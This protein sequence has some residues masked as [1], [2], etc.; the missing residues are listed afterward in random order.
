MK[1]LIISQNTADR[2]AKERGVA[3]TE[4][5][6]VFAVLILGINFMVDWGNNESLFE[7]LLDPEGDS[8]YNLIHGLS[9]Y[10]TRISDFVALPIP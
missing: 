1:P 9:Q 2:G 3:M 6:I 5:V 10:F 4:Y 7:V 8:P